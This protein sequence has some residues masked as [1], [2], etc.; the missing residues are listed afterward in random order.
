MLQNVFGEDMQI[1]GDDEHAFLKPFYLNW[2]FA[3]KGNIYLQQIFLK[4]LNYLTQCFC[5]LAWE[6]LVTQ[7]WWPY[8]WY[9]K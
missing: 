5:T 4:L 6:I 7:Y 9:W 8:L 1:L 2:I 3:H